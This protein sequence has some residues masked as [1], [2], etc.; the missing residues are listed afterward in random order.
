MEFAGQLRNQPI[1]LEAP[2]G[3]RGLPAKV[4]PLVTIISS[5][6]EQ[7]REVSIFPIVPASHAG[8]AVA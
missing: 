1:V 5:T 8:Y 2:G 7:S 6:L 3:K 4:R